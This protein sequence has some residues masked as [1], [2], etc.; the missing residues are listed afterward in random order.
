MRRGTTPTLTFTT[1]YEASLWVLERSWITFEQRGMILFSI[2]LD[3]ESVNVTDNAVTVTLTQEQTLSMTTAD[4]LSIQIR[5]I[6]G[7]N[8]AVGSNVVQ[9]IVC[10][11]LKDGEI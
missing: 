6:V 9:D 2:R 11:I 10:P 4:E 7:E 3:D 8:K 1:P 5:G